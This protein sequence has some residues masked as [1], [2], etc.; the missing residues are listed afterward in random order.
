LVV[1][2]AEVLHGQELAE[3]AWLACC[4]WV[5]YQ[6]VEVEVLKGHSKSVY[7]RWVVVVWEFR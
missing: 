2:G 5:G 1:E 4:I 7:D 6:K 3:V